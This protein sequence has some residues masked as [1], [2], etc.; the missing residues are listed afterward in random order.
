VRAEK[1]C[2]T[3]ASRESGTRY[4]PAVRR[5]RVGAALVVVAACALCVSTARGDTPSEMRAATTLEIY[6]GVGSW[7]DIFA[8]PPWRR[9]LSVAADLKARGVT[10]L[11]LQ[12]S[13]YS[14]R[15]AIVQPAL[16]GRLLDAA[17]AAGISVVAWYLP[18]FAD[19][20]TDARR[21][22][23]AIQFRSASGE[24]F[25]SF[26]LDIEAG[27]V[28]PASLRNSRLLALAA[29]VRAALPSDVPLGA[30]IPSPVGMDRHPHYWPGFP[31][32]G[33]ARLSDVFLPMA[34]FS[35]YVHSPA[36]V[37][38]YTRRV[39]LDIRD[40]TGRPDVPIHV[41]GGLASSTTGAAAI[42]FARAAT[43]CGVDGVS[44]YAYPQT[45][46]AQWH[47]LATTELVGS[48]AATGC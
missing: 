10:T 14:Q 22:L 28:H 1:R 23:A 46:F 3:P 2:Q 11:Y 24:R 43:E 34:Y 13:N 33:L 8:G 47:A 17:H 16:L 25:D 32:A 15:S 40:R 21:S 26:A 38:D 35:H 39:V 19:P 41:I 45:T 37:Y 30:I 42:A 9:P 4:D 18:S 6:G 12:T 36:D 31:Y 44:L 20:V 27:L 7:L 5:A 29:R 48:A